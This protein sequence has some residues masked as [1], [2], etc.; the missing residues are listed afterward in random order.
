M[1]FDPVDEH[2]FELAIELV[3]RKVAHWDLVFD[4]DTI[5]FFEMMGLFWREYIRNN[6]TKIKEK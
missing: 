4:E 1:E 2:D 6:W 5:L 3:L